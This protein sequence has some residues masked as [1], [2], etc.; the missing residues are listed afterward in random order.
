M[1]MVTLVPVLAKSRWPKHR[2]RLCM[3]KK[4]SY[5]KKEKKIKLVSQVDVFAGTNEV[6]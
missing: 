4:V 6:L 1:V 3:S 2:F 5:I